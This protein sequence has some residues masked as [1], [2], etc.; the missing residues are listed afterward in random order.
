MARKAKAR[1]DES[2][3]LIRAAEY[4]RTSTDEQRY[5]VENQTE[6]IREY[7]AGHG[8]DV[9]RTYIDYGK[10]GLHLHGRAGLKS[11]LEDVKSGDAGFSVVLVY[12]MSRWGRFQNIDES[13]YYDF[14]CRRA[15]VRVT[16]CTEVFETFDNATMSSVV[17]D[18]RRVMAADDSRAKSVK[19]WQGQRT[20]AGKGFLVTGSAALGLRRCLLDGTG[21]PKALLALGQRKAIRDDKVI[22]VPGPREEVEI[23]WRIFDLYTQTDLSSFDIAKLLNR[24]KVARPNGK[25]WNAIY[26][27]AVLNTFQYTGDNIYNRTSR[28]LGGKNVHNPPH[29]WVRCN[30]AFRPLVTSTMFEAAQRKMQIKYPSR[31]SE[32][33]L[34]RKLRELLQREGHLSMELI[35]KAPGMPGTATYIR[36]FGNMTRAFAAAGY[37][38]LRCNGWQERREALAGLQSRLVSDVETEL[39]SVGVH[40]VRE[41]DRSILRIE[42]RWSV[43]VR[44][45][46]SFFNLAEKG[47]Y[48]SIYIPKGVRCDQIL[49]AGLNAQNANVAALFLIP[50][51]EM[52]LPS[53]FR[54]SNRRFAPYRLAGVH[55][56]FPA[57]MK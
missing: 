17:K 27:R 4:I 26:V 43:Y 2:A 19:V 39:A 32:A 55:K 23:V 7:A 36:R 31:W 41:S 9:V 35:R 14:L 50:K 24:E 21:R 28:K 54:G 49:L 16:Y 33:D 1:S 13:A 5:S 12:D 20:I 53:Q 44:I 29:Q 42:G 51:R 34:T 8:M 25:A 38:S 46:G 40:S 18:L 47:Y 45:V 48:W 37:C 57:L 15:G 6:T 22:L 10:S 30:G 56:I 3:V 52:P 11:L